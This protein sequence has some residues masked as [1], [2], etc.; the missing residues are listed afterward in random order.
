MSMGNAGVS[1]CLG[2]PDGTRTWDTGQKPGDFGGGVCPLS[3]GHG[4][5]CMRVSKHM[6]DREPVQQ[7]RR[8]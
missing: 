6:N 4:Q 7:R 2:R 3:M 8:P 5:V 1:R